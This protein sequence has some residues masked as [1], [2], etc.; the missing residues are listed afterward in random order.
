M[1][2]ADIAVRRIHLRTDN[3]RRLF[4]DRWEYF[5]A[6]GVNPVIEASVD[7]IPIHY[8]TPVNL[9]DLADD[10]YR[11]FDRVICTAAL[12]GFVGN[13]MTVPWRGI[14]VRARFI[15][16][17]ASEGTV[18]RAYMVNRP[19]MEVPYTRTVETKHATGQAVRGTV[20]C[21]EYPGCEAKHYPVPTTD[22]RYERV[23]DALKQVIREASPIPVQF[24]GRL[25]NYAYIDQDTAILQG[26]NAAD[27]L[28]QG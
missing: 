22:H 12:D 13:G 15:D 21:E 16:T 19:G 4:A 25:A 10:L 11:R 27:E 8:G 3:N 17:D 1:L 7:G 6:T 9:E 20:V 18:T 2:S 26:M 5:G 28:L 24:C 23:N 14:E